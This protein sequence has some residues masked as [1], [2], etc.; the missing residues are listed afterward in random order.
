MIRCHLNRIYVLVLVTFLFSSSALVGAGTF[1]TCFENDETE[2][3][4]SLV[5]G[6]AGKMKKRKNI[7]ALEIATAM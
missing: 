3:I 1:D 4:F 5:L 6:K 2:S 7:I